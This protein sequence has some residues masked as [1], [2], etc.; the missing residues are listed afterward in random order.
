MSVATKTF[1]YQ[2]SEEFW[3]ERLDLKGI[4][5]NFYKKW[6]GDLD[7][8][9]QQGQFCRNDLQ[10]KVRSFGVSVMIHRHNIFIQHL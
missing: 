6:P 9:E 1:F 10:S 3:W 2:W 7:K 8:P 5:I 4:K